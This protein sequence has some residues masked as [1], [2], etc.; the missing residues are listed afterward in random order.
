MA[1]AMGVGRAALTLLGFVAIGAAVIFVAQRFMGKGDGNGPTGQKI[2]THAY[3]PQLVECRLIPDEEIPESLP[4]PGVDEDVVYIA[5]VVLY[6]GVDRVPEPRDHRLIGVNGADGF[7]EPLDVDY[8]LIEDGA[9]LTLVFRTDNS[10]RFAR[11]VRGAESLFD[12]V[13]LEYE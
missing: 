6:P 9:E 4:R 3:N 13:E 1:D 11:L 7:L 5:V 8:D 10:F 12:R 2:L